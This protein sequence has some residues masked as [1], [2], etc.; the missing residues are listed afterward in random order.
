[1]LTEAALGQDSLCFIF[2]SFCHSVHNSL[3]SP[4][5]STATDGWIAIETLDSTPTASRPV[6]VCLVRDGQY[7]LLY[8]IERCDDRHVVNWKE[9]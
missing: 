3:L 2:R 8:T 6:A 5:L 9:L 7:L 1:M 4:I